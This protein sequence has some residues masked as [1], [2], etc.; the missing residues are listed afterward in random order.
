MTWIASVMSIL[1]SLSKLAT[2]L[3]DYFKEKKLI[4]QGKT[5]E[6]AEIAIHE[7][8]INKKQTE[9]IMKDQSK[10]ETVKKLKDGTF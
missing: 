2:K 4:E 6:K 3:L 1:S 5:L 10:E 9:I 8:E 7:L